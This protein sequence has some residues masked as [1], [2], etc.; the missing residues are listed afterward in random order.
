MFSRTR[1]RRYRTRNRRYCTR[2][3]RYRTRNRRYCSPL[4]KGADGPQARRGI[5][6]MATVKSPR[7][8]AACRPPF[9]RGCPHP[10]ARLRRVGP[11][12]QG[13]PGIARL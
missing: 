9:T 5:C 7:T 3:R 12:S 2:N 6:E 10:P 13:G 11:L 1:N 8:P 4:S